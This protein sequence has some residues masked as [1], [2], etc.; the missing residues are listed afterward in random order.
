M[1][2][3]L[4]FFKYPFILFAT[5]PCHCSFLCS[6]KIIKGQ[7]LYF[8]SVSSWNG[9]VRA[10]LALC[11]TIKWDFLQQGMEVLRGDPHFY[12]SGKYSTLQLT[13]RINPVTSKSVQSFIFYYALILQLYCRSDSKSNI[14]WKNSN[15]TLLV[16]VLVLWHVLQVMVI[17]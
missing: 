5:H 14:A 4:Y 8:F 1:E 6:S 2:H 16:K 7:L 15:F 13:I 10:T 17:V 12:S 11:R 9:A 3:E